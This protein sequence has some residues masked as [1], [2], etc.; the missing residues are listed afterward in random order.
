MENGG[1]P[2][3]ATPETLLKKLFMLSAVDMKTK[4]TGDKRL[5]WIYGSVTEIFL[6]DSRCMPAKMGWRGFSYVNT[7]HLS[8]HCYTSSCVLYVAGC[9]SSYQQIHHSTD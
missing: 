2:Q 3:S 6:R 9:M 4:V 1:V 8:N 5:G 7:T